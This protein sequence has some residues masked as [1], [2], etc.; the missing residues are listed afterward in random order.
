MR[1]VVFN[2]ALMGLFIMSQPSTGL[3]RQNEKITIETRILAIPAL[4]SRM[5]DGGT[6]ED[7]RV[8]GVVMGGNVT[9]NFPEGFTVLEVPSNR[10]DFEFVGLIKDEVSAYPCSCGDFIRNHWYHD[11]FV[12]ISPKISWWR[13]AVRSVSFTTN[14]T[15][16]C[17]CYCFVNVHQPFRL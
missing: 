7:G 2:L 1:T 13:S 15:R 11:S 4:Q 3:P 6:L 9:R 16:Y 12:I 10:E 8:W 5:V 14:P 17:L